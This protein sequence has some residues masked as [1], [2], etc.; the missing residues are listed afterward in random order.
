MAAA[1]VEYERSDNFCEASDGGIV[2]LAFLEDHRVCSRQCWCEGNKHGKDD[3]LEVLVFCHTI[4]RQT[5][6]LAAL[7]MTK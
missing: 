1:A 6:L 4:L 3:L 7:S 5:L 2:L